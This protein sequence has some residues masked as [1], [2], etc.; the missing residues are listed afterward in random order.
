[1]S[2]LE[3]AIAFV[4]ADDDLL[5]VICTATGVIVAVVVVLFGV[6]HKIN[7]IASTNEPSRTPS[8]H[9]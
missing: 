5:E 2:C 1:M 8:M 4:D 6:N 7:R 9:P 3:R